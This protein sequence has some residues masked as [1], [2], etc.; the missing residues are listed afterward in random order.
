VLSVTVPESQQ[1]AQIVRELG[2]SGQ[3]HSFVGEL[4]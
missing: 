1:V 4:G 2:L 3:A